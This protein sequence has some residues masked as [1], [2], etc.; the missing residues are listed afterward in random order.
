MIDQIHNASSL[1]SELA[2]IRARYPTQYVEVTGHMWPV[3]DTGGAGRCMLLLPGGLATA[4]TAFRWVRRCA[5]RG[6][7][8]SLAY[9]ATLW[10]IG[11]VLRG[12]VSLLDRL[13]V[14]QAH[15]V[16]GSY[17]GLVAQCLVRAAPERIATLVLSDTGVPR[18]GRAQI[19]SLYGLVIRGLPL[20]LVRGMFRRGVSN[21]VRPLPPPMRQFWGSYFNA[22][23][24]VMQ[25]AAMLSLLAIW[26]D[27]DRNVR[28]AADDLRGWPGRV[29]L[30]EAERD[31]LFRP[32]ERRSLRALYPAAQHIAVPD[33]PHCASLALMDQ[34]IDWT[35]A[36]WEA[37]R[38][39]SH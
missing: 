10:D 35:E 2:A 28:F 15:V 18:P 38:A 19:Q 14:A 36:F 4:D 13:G 16:G 17:S 5:E 9:P 25:R 6:R 24:A 29:L 8:V 33:A 32:A 7:V 3:I 39:S 1:Y 22:N 11:T 34:Y 37:S 26:C 12:L 30:I 31:A 27:I 21:F 20:P 23:I